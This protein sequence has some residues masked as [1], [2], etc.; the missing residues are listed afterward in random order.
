M[1]SEKNL[2]NRPYVILNAAMSLDGKIATISGDAE[3]SSEADWKRV[4]KLRSE[5]DAIMVGIN[6]ILKDDP[7]LYIKNYTPNKFLRVIIDSIAHTP[8]NANLFNMDLSIYPVLIAVTNKAP[9]SKIQ[10]LKNKGAQ[11]L[12]TGEKNQVDLKKVMEFLVKMNIKKV[13]LEGGGTLNFSMI[14]NKFI[15]EVRVAIAPVLVGGKSATTLV[16]G[17]GFESVCEGFHLELDYIDQIGYNV[18]L[19]YKALF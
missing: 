17:L 18:V 8:P 3:F 13:L 9:K 5:M 6:T 7:K 2:K 4:H 15:D 11:I 10:Q 19:Y 16:D 1:P 14:E 12:E